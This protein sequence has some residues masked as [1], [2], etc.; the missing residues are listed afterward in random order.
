MSLSL[1]TSSLF[2]TVF[3]I[4]TFFF[5]YGRKVACLLALL[6]EVIFVALSVLATELW[7]F[8]ALRFLIGTGVG[9]TLLSCYIIIIELSG[10]SFRPYLTGLIETAYVFAYITL[11]FIAYFIRDWRYLQLATSLPWLF[12][13]F[14][15][16]LIPESPR[17]LI[18]M[19]HKERAIEVLTHIARK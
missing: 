16:Y 5:R 14:Y 11:P 13:I 9:G 15:Y 4:F 19:G 8:I 18:T 10:K 17:W 6:A 1:V 7:M 2:T 12:V 3:A